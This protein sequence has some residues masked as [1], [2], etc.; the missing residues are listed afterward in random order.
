MNFTSTMT[1]Q[2][3]FNI[4]SS[5]SP[6]V[7]KAKENDLNNRIERKMMT[8]QAY[9]LPVVLTRLVRQVNPRKLINIPRPL[10]SQVIIVF[11]LCADLIISCLKYMYR[12]NGWGYM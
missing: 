12:E 3:E 4:R 8:R 1:L 6:A 9:H 5:K 7:R 11:S 2:T 10:R